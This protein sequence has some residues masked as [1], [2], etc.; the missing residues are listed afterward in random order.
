MTWT[1]VIFF[2]FSSFSVSLP[3]WSF[4]RS[5]FC[6]WYSYPS[7]S[8]VI[9]YS[10]S[11]K[12]NF[13]C[14]INWAR[15]FAFFFPFFNIFGP[16]CIFFFHFSISLDHCCSLTSLLVLFSFVIFLELLVFTWITRFFY[17]H[18]KHLALIKL[19]ISLRLISWN[20][21]EKV[22]SNI[23]LEYLNCAFWEF[24]ILN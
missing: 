9:V 1:G 7:Y 22:A 11:R 18:S 8:R 13:C 23:Q 17:L 16:L 4:L 15:V 21:G 5:L 6:L 12:V 10:S 20:N 14:F 24:V 2:F 3:L 19:Y